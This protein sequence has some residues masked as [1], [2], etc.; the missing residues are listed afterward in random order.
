MFRPPFLLYK[1]CAVGR[2]PAVCQM[3][4]PFMQVVKTVESFDQE[5]ISSW[6]V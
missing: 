5:K 6:S 4:N 3:V 2:K 1:L